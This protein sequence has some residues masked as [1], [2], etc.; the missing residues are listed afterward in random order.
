MDACIEKMSYLCFAKAVASGLG[1]A[2][3]LRTDSPV[4]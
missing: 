3:S 1:G 2:K 4:R